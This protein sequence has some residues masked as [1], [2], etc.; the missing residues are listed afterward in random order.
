MGYAVNDHGERPWGFWH[1]DEVHDG[2]IVK[3]ITVKPGGVLSLQ[4]HKHRS[5][6]WEITE[7]FAE[8]TVGTTVM[9]LTIG[10]TVEI[11][12]NT[13]HRL[14]NFSDSLLIVKEKQFGDILDED[15]IVRYEDIYGRG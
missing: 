1:V 8:V 4:S 13:L 3:T 5:E 11:P 6:I 14:A 7:G 2:Y 15:D 12:V 9:Q 10:E